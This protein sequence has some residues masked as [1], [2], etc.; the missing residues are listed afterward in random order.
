MTRCLECAC[1]TLNRAIDDLGPNTKTSAQAERSLSPE[2]G[3][4]PSGWE[5][6]GEGEHILRAERSHFYRGGRG[7]ARPSIITFIVVAAEWPDPA[8]SL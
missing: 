3:K 1:T 2:Y 7:V 8:L 6:R 4:F 5:L